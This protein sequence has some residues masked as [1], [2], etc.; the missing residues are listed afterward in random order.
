[1]SEYETERGQLDALWSHV[2]HKEQDDEQEAEE[3]KK[4]LL[5]RKSLTTGKESTG[6]RRGTHIDTQ[7]Y[8]GHSIAKTEAKASE[9]VLQTLR[10][11]RGHPE[12]P[13]TGEEA[14]LRGLEVPSGDQE[15]R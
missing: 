5:T 7:L 15:A 13:P 2:G 1:M 8:V 11:N 9:E 12:K 6:A 4:K 14:S 10:Q 3:G